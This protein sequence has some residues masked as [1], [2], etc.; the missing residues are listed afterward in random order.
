MI[1]VIG[2]LELLVDHPDGGGGRA[3]E[4]DLHGGV[5]ERDEAG[6]EVEVAGAEDDQEEDLGLAGD[7]GAASGLPDLEEEQDDGQ[8]VGEVPGQPKQIHPAASG[9]RDLTLQGLVE[10]YFEILQTCGPFC[11]A[12]QKG[13]YG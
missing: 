4:E 11:Y 7:A 5:V 1:A 12:I 3:H 8:Q 9:N 13:F 2:G 6:E 10:E